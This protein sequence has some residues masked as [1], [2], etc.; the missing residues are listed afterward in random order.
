MISVFND[1]YLGLSINQDTSCTYCICCHVKANSS[2][3]MVG[4]TWWKL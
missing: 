2:V 4:Y 1:R 3:C